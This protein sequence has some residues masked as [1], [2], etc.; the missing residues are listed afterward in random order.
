MKSS[1]ITPISLVA[2]LLFSLQTQAS[3]VEGTAHASLAATDFCLV[4]RPVPAVTVP[5]QGEWLLRAEQLLSNPWTV[6]QKAG[7]GQPLMAALEPL[8]LQPAVPA[9]SAVP[10][11][12]S[13]IWFVQNALALGVLASYARSAG[14]DVDD[15]NLLGYQ[16][17][18]TDVRLQLC[19]T[20]WLSNSFYLT[21]ALLYA[22]N[23]QVQ[24][25][26][27]DDRYLTAST[28]Y[29]LSIGAGYFKPCF[30]RFGLMTGA[31]LSYQ[32]GKAVNK[33]VIETPSTETKTTTGLWE[34]QASG[35]LGVW[36]AMNR[37]LISAQLGLISYR[38]QNSERS[39]EFFEFEYRQRESELLVGLDTKQ[40]ALGLRYLLNKR[41]SSSE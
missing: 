35:Y 34:A 17:T 37:Y 1:R 2:L 3:R 20:Y 13:E 36:Y 11:R 12:L 40:F 24:R 30:T 7:S 15:G 23:A 18:F 6:G 9:A 25:T 39:G 32:M 38:Y 41:T 5:V 4:D 26:I 33:V 8:A 10:D 19:L 22:R 21:P 16:P 28:L 14:R 29:G 27:A 31:D